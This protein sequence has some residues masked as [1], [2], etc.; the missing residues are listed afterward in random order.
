MIIMSPFVF[1]CSY[2]YFLSVEVIFIISQLVAYVSIGSFKPEHLNC[3][4]LVLGVV[5][6]YYNSDGIGVRDF[7][8]D[9]GDSFFIFNL[10]GILVFGG[11]RGNNFD[12]ILISVWGLE[13]FRLV[14]ETFFQN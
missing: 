4:N 14:F 12:C 1:V 11:V 10:S 9:K 6:L 5:M 3:N 7:G 13:Y 2:V 8:C